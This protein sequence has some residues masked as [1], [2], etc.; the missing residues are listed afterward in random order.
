MNKALKSVLISTLSIVLLICISICGWFAYIVFF[1]KQ[2]ASSTTFKVGALTLADGSQQNLVEIQY[3]AN[4]DNSGLE[5]FEIKFNYFMDEDREDFYSQGL[6]YTSAD[7]YSKISFDIGHND[8]TSVKVDSSGV[9]GWKKKYYE[10]QN[11]YVPGATTN[12]FNYQEIAESN[13]VKSTHPI[14]LDSFFKIQLSETLALMQFKGLDT[15]KDELTHLSEIRTYHNVWEADTYHDMYAIYNAEYFSKLLYE[16]IKSAELGANY[17]AVFE[18]GDLFWYYQATKDDNTVYERI[19][20][21]VV[22]GTGEFL[23]PG[24]IKDYIQ[25]YYSIRIKT[26]EY[27]LQRAQDSMF[28][29]VLGNTNY[30]STGKYTSDDYFVGRTVIDCNVYSFEFVNDGLNN[31]TLKLSDTF[32]N[33]YK[34]YKN[35]I[36]LNVVIDLDLIDNLGYVFTDFA[37]DCFKEFKVLRCYTTSNSEIVKDYSLEVQ[38]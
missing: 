29:S 9:L 18:F 24:K 6:Q 36:V 2:K 14:G 22:V 20:E 10:C 17:D 25:S 11:S 26:F 13:Y 35:S 23:D 7:A 32:V 3:F 27:G 8:I 1:A 16:S 33:Y 12:F 31:L 21:P 34:K 5:A 38:V 19:N 4:K 37:D 15:P 30:N 28:K